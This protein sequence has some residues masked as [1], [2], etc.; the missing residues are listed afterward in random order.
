MN[1]LGPLAGKALLVAK[2]AHMGQKRKYTGEDYVAHPIRVSWLVAMAGGND[3]MQAAALLHDVVEDTDFTIREVEQM[4]GMYVGGMVADL[5]NVSK[6][7]PDLNRDMRKALD[8]KQATM[9][10]QESKT[11]RLA[12]IIDNVPSTMRY[13]PGFAAKYVKEKAE[14]MPILRDGDSHLYTLASAILRVGIK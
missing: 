14:L 11:I 1:Q 13:D 12:D 3:A 10:I 4:F 9:I 5:T 6:S 2:A 7:H 8:R